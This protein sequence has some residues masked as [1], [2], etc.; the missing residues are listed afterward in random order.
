MERGCTDHGCKGFG[1]GYATGYYKG[2]CG[3]KK[4]TTKHRIAYCKHNGIHPED[5]DKDLVVRHKCDNAR[6]INPLH[7]EVGTHADNMQ[8]V[9]DRGRAYRGGRP[10]TLNGR[11]VLSDEAVEQI[12]QLRATTKLSYREIG[13]RFGV[14]ISQVSRIV[15]GEQRGNKAKG[16]GGS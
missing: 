12:R 4:Y 9:V 7:L 6:C 10:G 5:L 13:E 3:K 8:D 15:K 1:L 14:G 2:R 16:E 11:C